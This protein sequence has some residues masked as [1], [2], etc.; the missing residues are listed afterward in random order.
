M[1]VVAE[2]K[3]HSAGLEAEPV[4]VARTVVPIDNVKVTSPAVGDGE[5]AP[6]PLT[7]A[8]Q[9]ETLVEVPEVVPELSSLMVRAVVVAVTPDWV[10]LQWCTEVVLPRT[11]KVIAYDFAPVNVFAA[12]LA[13]RETMPLLHL[14]TSANFAIFGLDD[15]TQIVAS[16]TV[17][18][19]EAEPPDALM[20][21]AVVAP[22]L[23]RASPLK[24]AMLTMQ[25]ANLCIMSASLKSE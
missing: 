24:I 21:F 9:S 10:T 2:L 17:A 12:N 5:V 7:T 11:V 23:G 15:Q 14:T 25:I 13:A 18:A 6:L 22:E 19:N 16:L 20:V 3:L 1:P 8:F 4:K